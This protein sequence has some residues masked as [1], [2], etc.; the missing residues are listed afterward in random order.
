MASLDLSTSIQPGKTNKN[1]FA[2][3]LNKNASTPIHRRKDQ[4]RARSSHP[5]V[6]SFQSNYGTY[7]AFEVDVASTDGG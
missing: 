5:C 1:F 7:M 2:T 4:G 3:I 6:I